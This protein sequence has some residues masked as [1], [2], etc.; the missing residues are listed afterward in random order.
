MN[1]RQISL[2]V[3]FFLSAALLASSPSR[4]DQAAPAANTVNPPVAPP[5][6]S[7][8]APAKSEARVLKVTVVD[9]PECDS[10]FA[11]GKA[12]V[13]T[14]DKDP[15]PLPTG[16]NLGPFLNQ[17][18]IKGLVQQ[19][20]PRD[21]KF[22]DGLK[23][24]SVPDTAV[25]LRFDLKQTKDNQDAWSRLLG[26]KNLWPK[27]TERCDCGD[28]EKTSFTLGL[29]DGSW[30]AGTNLQVKCLEFFPNPRIA[31]MVF[32]AF[33][34]IAL[35]TIGLGVKSSMLRD[36]GDP[37]TDGKLGTFSLARCQMALWFV[38]VIL[39]SLFIYGVTGDVPPIPQ[40][41]L[42]LMGIGA[43]TA[44]GAAAID[45]NK[46][47]ASKQDLVNLTAESTTL[48]QQ[49]ADLTKRIAAA[50]AGDPN[51]PLW[52]KQLLDA[53][54][55]QLVVASILAAIPST[56]VAPSE[57]IFEDLLSDE[58]GISFHRLQVLGW[59]LVFWVVF[60]QSLFGK[61]T[62]VDFDTTQLALMGI[63]GTTYLGFKLQ[64]KQS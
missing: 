23:P 2:P 43:G 48:P 53:Q 52:Q 40:G 36:S 61:L 6:A 37:R 42:I 19:W 30:F 18:L 39:A 28:D 10:E 64:E 58:N 35:M 5:A 60:L 31:W 46:R 63:S 27:R 3:A 62:M 21:S 24:E 22:V 9:P 12:I 49:I 54:Q 45:L 15:R 33:G 50:Q 34:I 29:E 11:L 56:Q 55:R 51:L 26:R 4:A 25:F 41:T 59:T 16:K 57:G 32:L 17:V 44:L 8:T 47:T 20:V 7:S 14:L 13:F 38:T 1:R